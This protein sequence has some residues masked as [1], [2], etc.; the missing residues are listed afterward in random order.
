MLIFHHIRPWSSSRFYHHS[1]LPHSRFP[2]PDCVTRLELYQRL[3]WLVII[4]FIFGL[5][6]YQI[7][8]A[9]WKVQ[10]SIAILL[11]GVSGMLWGIIG[12]LGERFKASSH[13]N[14]L[15]TFGWDKI[16]IRIL[17][18]VSPNS[19]PTTASISAQPRWLYQYWWVPEVFHTPPCAVILLHE[20]A[21]K[22]GTNWDFV[23]V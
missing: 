10:I 5:G 2:I 15:G 4:L 8:M 17:R 6:S 7:S 9:P 21:S 1:R 13:G 22:N 12:W 20:K 3:C 19:F 14:S 23:A 11:K 16:A 18:W